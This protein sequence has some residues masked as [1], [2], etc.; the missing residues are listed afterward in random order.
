MPPEPKNKSGLL[1]NTKN[2]GSSL[3]ILKMPKCEIF[4]LLDFNDVYVIKPL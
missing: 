1:G 2:V 3:M 4:D